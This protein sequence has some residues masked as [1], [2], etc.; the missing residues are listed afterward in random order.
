MSAKAE[1]LLQCSFCAKSQ[2]QVRKLIAGPGVYIC[3]QCVDLCNEIID[4]ETSDDGLAA[5]TEA[6]SRVDRLVDKLKED[7]V[8]WDE[9]AR[10]LRKETDED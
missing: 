1:S 8:P 10:A 7:G 3:D 5:L 9:I 2:E 4:D 6:S